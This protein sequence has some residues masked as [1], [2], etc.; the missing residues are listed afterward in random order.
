MAAKTAK[1]L[2]EEKK[3][4]FI[5]KR[6]QRTANEA[7]NNLV[8]RYLLNAAKL[9]INGWPLST[10]DTPA[11]VDYAH[12]ESD[13]DAQYGAL[14]ELIVESPEGPSKLGGVYKELEKALQPGGPFHADT[15]AAK[16]RRNRLKAGFAAS[17]QSNTN[18]RKR[19]HAV[20][21]LRESAEDYL[22]PDEGQTYD[23]EDL[24]A[25]GLALIED[26]TYHWSP[27]KNTGPRVQ[28]VID[29]FFPLPSE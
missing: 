10:N 18:N 5:R 24:V 28:A 23:E 8:D 6:A 7:K 16:Q 21:Y 4:G 17:Q 25:L 26:D 27:R 1:Q 20:D 22:P 29:E 11:S 14:C 19:Q 15:T 12:S 3:D 2:R 9:Y 13:R